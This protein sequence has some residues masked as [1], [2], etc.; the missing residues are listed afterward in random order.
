MV[1]KS[2]IKHHLK[3]TSTLWFKEKFLET[4]DI[5]EERIVNFQYLQYKNR[6]MQILA[7]KIADG[8]SLYRINKD[9]FKEMLMGDGTD[10]KE[11]GRVDMHWLGYAHK[12]YTIDN[13]HITGTASSDNYIYI[14][15][16][17][18]FIIS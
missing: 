8:S 7:Y 5:I 3:I 13:L 1:I 11:T 18:N 14:M 10:S 15:A 9:A 16:T 6:H 12:Y 2:K 4:R 17:N